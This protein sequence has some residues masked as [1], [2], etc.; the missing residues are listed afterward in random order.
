[1]MLK[2]DNINFKGINLKPEIPKWLSTVILILCWLIIGFISPFLYSIYKKDYTVELFKA[3]C[4]VSILGPI[5]IFIVLN[6]IT[7][8]NGD[9]ILIKKVNKNGDKITQ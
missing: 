6:W 4:L 2:K 9:Y 1:M 8:D 7:N 3:N 5:N